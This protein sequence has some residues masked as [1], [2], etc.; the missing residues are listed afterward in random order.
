MKN[1][2]SS[3]LLALIVVTLA[4]GTG[5]AL[6]AALQS[7]A[8]DLPDGVF[9][10]QA[11]TDIRPWQTGSIANAMPA[12]DGSF[13]ATIDTA[14]LNKGRHIGLVR[15]KDTSNSW[16]AFSAVFFNVAPTSVELKSFA[17]TAA[18]RAIIVSWET[19]SELDNLGFNLYRATAVDG[20]K[21]KLN[22]EL[23]PTLVPPGSPFGAAYLYEDTAV[24]AGMRYF[25]WLELV[26]IYG[27]TN[28]HGPVS[29]QVEWSGRVYLP[30]ILADR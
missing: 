11:Y 23:I 1:R 9:V 13:N 6:A 27:S 21:S 15:G 7:T 29:A 10:V 18:E 28:L 25:Y 16:G 30:A 12:S 5:N 14:S 3:A 24:I 8:K 26:D 2:L 19:T 4:T 17:A 22:A 20:P